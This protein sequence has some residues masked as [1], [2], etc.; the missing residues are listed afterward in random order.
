MKPLAALVLTIAAALALTAQKPDD[1]LATVNGQPIHFRD[2]SEDTQ[3]IVADVPARM[4]KFRSDILGQLINERALAA[5]AKAVGS[6]PG[7][8]V[9]AEKAKVPAPTDADVQAVIDANQSALAGEPPTEVRKKVVAYLRAE[10]EQKVLVTYFDVLTKKYI[11]SMGKD[12]NGQLIA[13]SD[14]LATVAGQPITY[15]EYEEYARLQLWNAK[16]DVADLIADELNGLIFQKLLAEE[17]KAQNIGPSDLLAREVTN[18]LKDY[19]DDERIGLNDALAKRLGA[20]YKVVVSYKRPDP[21]VEN[22]SAGTS[23][24]KGPVGAPVTIVMF[25]DF[26]CPAC[27]ATDPILKKVM[28]QYPGKIRFVV[29][30]YPLQEIHENAYRAALAAAAANKQGK[31]FDYIDILYHNQSA[32]DDASLLKYATGLGLNAQQFE[33]DFKSDATAAEVKKDVAD[34]ESYHI[35][36]TP[37]IFINGVRIRDLSAG[38]FKAA[39]DRA[40][41]K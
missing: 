14:V 32:L 27:S 11:A 36:G 19:T 21:I 28:D 8:L 39:I 16:A 9:A 13:P 10:P 20:K 4:A 31:F 35:T 18:K 29:R 12:V 3:K 26:Q 40:L 41:V 34:G 22:I 23:P 17:A 7:K 33:L 25:S 38:A 37:T 5:E 30:D 15:K 24:A 1:V 2:L 6:T